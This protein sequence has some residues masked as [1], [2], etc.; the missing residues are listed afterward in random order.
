[1]ST[2]SE[3]R[4]LLK[5]TRATI[6]VSA[7][8]SNYLAKIQQRVY[9]LPRPYQY[10]FANM[11]IR[12]VNLFQE[13][14]KELDAMRVAFNN[15]IS[16]AY[17]ATLVLGEKGSGKT[18]FL[19]YFSKQIGS[20]YPVIAF[21][22]DEFL[23]TESDFYA[24]VNKLF[25]RNDLDTD[26]A[27]V[28]YIGALETRYVIMVDGMERLFLRRLD[29]FQLI[30]KLL[31][32]ILA[33]NQQIFWVCSLSKHAADYLDKTIALG[34]YFD[35]QV[36]MD[37]ISPR[38][39]KGIIRRRNRIGG[40]RLNYLADPKT[41][42]AR[43]KEVIG[44]DELE[45]AFFQ[46]LGKFA[47]NNIAL[48]MQYWLESIET[49][50]EELVSVRKFV[51]PDFNFLESLSNDKLY[52]L[53]LIVLHGKMTIGDFSVIANQTSAQ[54]SRILNILKEDS[55]LVKQGSDFMLNGFLY[56]HVTRLLITRNLIN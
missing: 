11:P 13:R 45:E 54:S 5:L 46:E 27:I 55:I 2:V 33:T 10:L 4:K 51:V 28:A 37:G 26:D 43:S 9:D 7:E 16:G 31:S 21:Q 14:E 24:L 49:V 52:A 53:L 35:Y 34:D 29:G 32:L 36:E 17:A 18:S 40:F 30:H 20:A 15:W 22:S 42:E 6:R 38:L 44:Q 3:V 48:S 56:R 41:E 25:Q 50:N 23:T 47:G 39:I 8:M 1:E 12:E 19:H